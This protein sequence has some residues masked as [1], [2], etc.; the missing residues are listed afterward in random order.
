MCPA[1]ARI[2]FCLYLLN[3]VGTDKRMKY[4]FW[5]FIISQFV[6]NVGTLVEVSASC[7]RFAALWDPSVG[8]RCWSP[9]IQANVGFFQ[10][11]MLCHNFGVQLQPHN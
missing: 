2:S 1:F 11:G 3:F 10:G 6:V 8:G 4:L 5:F 7:V 9:R